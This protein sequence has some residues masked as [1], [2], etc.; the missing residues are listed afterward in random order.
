[1]HP[2]GPPL[3]RRRVL[4]LAA[5]SGLAV[6]T[7]STTGAAAA[8]TGPLDRVPRTLVSRG[9]VGPINAPDFPV[10]HLGLTWTGEDSHGRYRLRRAGRWGSWQPVR[11]T[12][13]GVTGRRASLV[14]V[15][16]ADAY[17]VDL[18]RGAGDVRVA[19]INTVD[20]PPG[21]TR[22]PVRRWSGMPY[23]SRAAW[24]ADESLRFG[25]DGSE[26]LPSEYFDVQTLTVHH[27]ATANADPDPA[28]TVRAVYAFQALPPQDF[29]DL[30]Y[31]LLID[32]AGRVYEGRYSGRDWLPVFGG[33]SRRGRPQMNNGAHVAGFNAG[34]VGIALLG[35]LTDQGPSSAARRSLVLVLAVL[36]R[37]CGLDPRGTTDY[38][39]PISGDTATVP[40]ISGHRDWVATACP[41]DAFYPR[42][43]VVRSDVVRLLHR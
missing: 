25:P 39:N 37:I 12:D 41:G 5:A 21:A 40:T 15:G 22:R 42:L 24:G 32:E 38:M 2:T 16:R 4:G 19:A 36:S 30:G 9:S 13:A 34:N 1:M 43:G 35:E 27:T 6:A 3:G 7:G 10:H 17:Q 14:H 18:D 8:P 23:L 28:A 11:P 20:G 29:G 33:R 31:H 26:G